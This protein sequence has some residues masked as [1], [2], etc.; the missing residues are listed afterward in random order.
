LGSGTVESSPTLDGG[1]TIHSGP[2]RVDGR[3][4]P[5]SGHSDWHGSRL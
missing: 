3:S 1:S 2:S 5:I 4:T